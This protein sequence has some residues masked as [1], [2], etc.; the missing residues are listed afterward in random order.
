MDVE[1]LWG[2]RIVLVW[3][4]WLVHCLGLFV[5]VGGCFHEDLFDRDTVVP[6][7]DKVL[8]KASG[9]VDI[10]LSVGVLY[11]VSSEVAIDEAL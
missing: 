10:V 6:T 9:G 2:D 8:G 1:G 4:T 5:N 11:P 7:I 3:F